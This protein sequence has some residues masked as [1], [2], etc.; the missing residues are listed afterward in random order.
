MKKIPKGLLDRMID[1]CR[2]WWIE[3]DEDAMSEYHGI[4]MQIGRKIKVNWFSIADVACVALRRDGF[5]PDAPNET[6]YAVLNVLGWEV[7]DENESEEG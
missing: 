5:A 2:K 1:N 6:I 3:N 7:V 4:A